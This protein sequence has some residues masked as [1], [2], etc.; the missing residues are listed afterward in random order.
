MSR[1]ILT[2]IYFCVFLSHAFFSSAQAQESELDWIPP[3]VTIKSQ[4]CNENNENANHCFDDVSQLCD[5]HRENSQLDAERFTLE[6]INQTDIYKICRFQDSIYTSNTVNRAAFLVQVETRKCTNPDYQHGVDSDNLDGI[7]QCHKTSCPSSE[8]FWSTGNGVSTPSG[9]IC[10]QQPSADPNVPGLMCEYEAIENSDGSSSDFTFQPS[11]S[12]CNCS[13]EAI[14]CADSSEGEMTDYPQGQDGCVQVADAVMCE[15]NPDEHCSGGVCDSG[16]GY[17]GSKFVCIE[18]N[19]SDEDAQ[20]C[21]ANDPRFG[22]NGKEEGECPVGVLN[23]LN[24]NPDDETPPDPCV[25]N[26]PRPECEGVPTGDPPPS[27]GEGEATSED[28]AKLGGKLDTVNKNLK[29]IKGDTKKM[30][31]ELTKEIDPPEID[32]DDSSDWTNT[33]NLVDQ[34]TSGND[35][36]VDEQ[37]FKTEFQAKESFFNNQI[38][39]VLP[40]AGSCGN[41]TMSFTH[42]NVS[43]STCEH[44][45]KVRQVIEWSLILAFLFYIRTAFERLKPNGA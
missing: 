41:L 18:T 5:W 11:G 43:I 17:I 24:E 9:K 33:K 26:D 31:D 28:I 10:V 21:K 4:W 35:V 14:P 27:E 8:F 2:T 36:N 12:G 3:E 44:L 37:N 29:D 42:A 20:S 16:C 23:C 19:V 30:L 6:I 13:S 39:G 32:P 1:A 40:N 22:C 45:S 15:A 25:E 7:D 38:A 34:Y